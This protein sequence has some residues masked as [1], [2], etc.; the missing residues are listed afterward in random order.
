M[1]EQYLLI[2]SLYRNAPFPLPGEEI[3][4]HPL[5]FVVSRWN[6]LE[7]LYPKRPCS[8]WNLTRLEYPPR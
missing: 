4:V 7:G 1:E 2:P 8:W 3:Q 5:P 6:K